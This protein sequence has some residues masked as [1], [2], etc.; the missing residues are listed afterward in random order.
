MAAEPYRVDAYEDAEYRRQTLRH[1][2]VEVNFDE[3]VSLWSLLVLY[4]RASLVSWV[5][6]IVVLVFWALLQIG[7]P[8][9]TNFGLLIVGSLASLAVFFV[10]L[11]GSKVTEPIGE[12]KSVLE[13]RA[14]A[15]TSAY[16][17]IC[18]VLMRRAIPAQPDV[19]RF[20][21]ARGGTNS[22]LTV[23]DGSYVAYVS[24][25]PYGTTL[26]LGWTMWRVRS[27]AALIWV[28]VKDMFKNAAGQGGLVNQ[29]LRTERARA[30]REAVHAAVREGVDVAVRDVEVSLIDVLGF[31]PPVESLP[32]QATNGRAVPGAHAA[33]AAAAAAQQ[34]AM[35]PMPPAPNGR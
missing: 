13:G 12:W 26:Y 2:Q 20:R 30:M 9:G 28:F 21:L 19:R 10:V 27:G 34:P 16:A 11:L 17:R 32:T 33:G 1:G 5:F 7:N 14:A 15:E 23:R 35:P 18:D 31:E 6:Y 8:G 24:V 29:M 25:F 3:S 4:V 22:R